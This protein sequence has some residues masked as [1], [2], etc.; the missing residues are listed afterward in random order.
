M[1]YNH[2]PVCA[3]VAV[4]FHWMN[5][6]VSSVFTC[7]APWFLGVRSE[8]LRWQCTMFINEFNVFPPWL[9]MVA[10][11]RNR[12]N[13]I[14]DFGMDQ[15]M[16]IQSVTR[17]SRCFHM[18]CVCELAAKTLSAPFRNLFCPNFLHEITSRSTD[19]GET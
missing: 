6:W 2:Q 8:R 17:N 18:A 10:A 13:F 9:W 16:I 7:P 1:G 12:K 5:A 19:K 4:G 11:M 3:K 15:W 14:N